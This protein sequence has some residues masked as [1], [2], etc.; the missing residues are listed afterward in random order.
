MRARLVALAVLAWAAPAAAQPVA[1]LDWGRPRIDPVCLDPDLEPAAAPLRD[2]GLDVARSA[3]TETALRARSRGAALI[4]TGDFFGTLDGSLRLT[5]RWV[6]RGGVELEAG[7]RVA[8]YRFAQNAVLTS[9][10][11]SAGPVWIGVSQSHTTRALGYAATWAPQLRLELPRSGSASD[12]TELAASPAVVLSVA[13]RPNFRLHV[14]SGLLL[15]AARPATGFDTRAAVAASADA[16]WRAG[17]W[18]ALTGGI[19]AQAG[20][21][22]DFD[23]LLGR[24]AIRVGGRTAVD[25]AAAAPVPELG[26]ERID[27]VVT[28]GIGRRL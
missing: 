25:L 9:S 8:D 1:A 22:G 23:H 26:R 17:R 21:R 6:S 2:S 19:E 16:A 15:W 24:A 18:L 13:L 7:A 5:G 28:L 12:L 4:D 3:C 27:L 11:L 14:R 10:E 20:W